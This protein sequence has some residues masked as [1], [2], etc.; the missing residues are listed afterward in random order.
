MKVNSAGELVGKVLAA[1]PNH[2][3][4]FEVYFSGTVQGVG[5]RYSA[6]KCSRHFEVLGTIQN[7]TDGRVKL[8]CEGSGGELE[9]FL[10]DIGQSTHGKITETTV[11]RSPA[12]CE[13]A[14]FEIIR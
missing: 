5:F 11:H 4:R 3:I 13:F 8:V 1:E 9:S 14:G 10:K 7:L 2:M 6:L 12:T